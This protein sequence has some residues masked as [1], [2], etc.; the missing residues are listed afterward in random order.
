MSMEYTYFRKYIILK[1]DYTNISNINPKG[2]AKVEVRG[3]KGIINFNLDNCELEEH[4]RV[5]LIKEK[6]GTIYEEDLGRIFTDE[7][8]RCK[9][10]ITLN[11]RELESKGLLIDKIDAILI[12]RGIYVLLGGYIDK[13]NKVIG[14]LIKQLT[15]EED[16]E[17]STTEPEVEEDIKEVYDLQKEDL[18]EE[19]I[20]EVVEEGIEKTPDFPKE[21][22]LEEIEYETIKEDEKEDEIVKEEAI[23]EKIMEEEE[24]E[25]EEFQEEVEEEIT[26]EEK[27]NQE[28]SYNESYENLEYARR[29][30]HKNQMTNYILSILRFFPQ[31]EPLKIYL[32]NYSWWRIDDDGTEP[33][34]GFL[35]YYNYLMSSDYKYPFLHN[36]TTCINQIR[37]YG[38]YLFGLYKER[39]EAKFYVYGVP[40]RFTPDEHPFKGITGFNTWYD[41]IDGIGYWILYIDPIT[42]KVIYPINPMVPSY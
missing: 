25:G 18:I 9:A 36:S 14:R 3:N 5:Y 32:H 23:E 34:R 11:L 4:Y 35:P 30:Q 38:H 37:K 16:K 6:N 28:Y 19:S 33:Y 1:N 40:G 31:V 39:Q 17:I 12:R 2:H 7:R 10:N 8:G 22:L 21:E 27:E 24:V 20:E 42:G 29:L 15:W 41:S 26:I 13:D